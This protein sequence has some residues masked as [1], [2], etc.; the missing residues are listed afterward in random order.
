[1]YFII[2]NNNENHAIF[3][4][5]YNINL[6]DISEAVCYNSSEQNH[7]YPWYTGTQTSSTN[8]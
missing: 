1:M 5:V 8:H 6:S 3:T 4:T 7:V 2:N